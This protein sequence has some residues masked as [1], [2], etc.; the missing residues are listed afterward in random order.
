MGFF[1]IFSGF[2]A[3][4]LNHQA[5]EDLIQVL[6]LGGFEGGEYAQLNH[7]FVHHVVQ[8]K[9]VGTSFLKRRLIVLQSIAGYARKQLS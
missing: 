8:G 6:S 1:Q 2:N 5:V 3:A 9:Q 7:F 4:K